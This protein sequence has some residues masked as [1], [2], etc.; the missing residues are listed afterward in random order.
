MSKYRN[1]LRNDIKIC[2][3]LL[4][5]E[6]VAESE[7]SHIKAK[8]SMD[9]PNFCSGF[10]NFV[11]TIGSEHNEK[12]NVKI[13]KSKLEYLL[14]T[15]T[16]RHQVE[17]NNRT[18]TINVNNTLNNFVNI[19][20]DI[21]EIRE[22]INENTYLGDKDKEELLEKL[23]QII[24]LQNSNESKSKKWNVAKSILAFIID[25]GADI[26]I[27]YIPQILKALQ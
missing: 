3:E 4:A 19:N 5:K 6:Y 11:K 26:A 22:K 2:E 24:D 14:S 23:D 8:Y 21:C 13:L 18:Q 12:E 1:E 10:K 16:M 17:N 15:S 25:K 9:N 20:M 27:M 7:F